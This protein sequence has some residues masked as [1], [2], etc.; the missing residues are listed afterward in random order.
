MDIN[1]ANEM[2]PEMKMMLQ[3]L[4]IKIDSKNEKFVDDFVKEHGGY[5]A[6]FE[7]IKQTTAPAVT[8]MKMKR[9]PPPPPIGVPS[10]SSTLR[11]SQSAV[12]TN[13]VVPR[14][15]PP[16]EPAKVTPNEKKTFFVQEQD[17]SF[18]S[19]VSPPPPPLPAFLLKDTTDTVDSPANS[20]TSLLDSIKNFSQTQLRKS[21]A[22]QTPNGTI[23]G[24]NTMLNQLLDALGKRQ[25]FMGKSS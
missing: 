24:E 22:E 19:I 2:T 6:L 7:E 9:A 16:L 11:R 20:S 23:Y 12:T 5:K 8:S 21:S 13:D 14:S 17:N 3:Q 18:N 10:A 25:Q 4:N 15:L 1:N